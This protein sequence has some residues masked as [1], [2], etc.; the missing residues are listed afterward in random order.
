M[1]RLARWLAALLMLAAATAVSAAE[2]QRILFIGNS[3]TMGANS[4]AERY[5][6]DTVTDLNGGKVGGVPAIFA[7][8]ARQAG[9]DWQVSHELVGGTTLGFH[10]NE[11]RALIDAPW[12]AVVLQ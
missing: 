9:L 1:T 6:A 3:F 12:D 7:A 5:G 4:A 2:P 8:F 10:L 11:K